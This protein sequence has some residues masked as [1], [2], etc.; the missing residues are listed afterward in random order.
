L[1]PCFAHLGYVP[2]S[3]PVTEDAMRTVISLPV[4]PELTDAAQ[5][6]VI[7]AVRGFFG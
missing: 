5:D 4:F 2:G 3:L 6:V 1:Q 7:G